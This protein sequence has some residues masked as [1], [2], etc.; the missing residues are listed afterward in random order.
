[1]PALIIGAILGLLVA[2]AD[3]LEKWAEKQKK[4]EQKAKGFIPTPEKADE[5]YRTLA[6]RLTT[7][8]GLLALALTILFMALL[9][10]LLALFGWLFYHLIDFVFSLI[11]GPLPA[12][13]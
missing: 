6:E 2:L 4:Q 3:P 1:M 5:Y 7:W 13:A 9:F 12:G 11:F 8:R 10:A